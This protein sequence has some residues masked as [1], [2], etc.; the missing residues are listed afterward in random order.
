MA[1]PVTVRAA[2]QVEVV[3]AAE[4]CE[5]QST[6]LGARFVDTFDRFLDTVGRQPRLYGLVARPPRGREVR[7]GLLTPFQWVVTYEVTPAGVTVLSVTHA[8]QRTQPWR[9]RLS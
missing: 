3:D 2:A 6:G 9:R 1:V 4:G 7:S 8:R 5:F